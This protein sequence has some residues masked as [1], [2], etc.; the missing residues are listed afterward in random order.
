MIE[1]N[2]GCLRDKGGIVWPASPEYGY[3]AEKY[4]R[5][6]TGQSRK[7]VHEK[8]KGLVCLTVVRGET[9]YKSQCNTLNN[10]TYHQQHVI[11]QL[12]STQIQIHAHEHML[13]TESYKRL[14]LISDTKQLQGDKPKHRC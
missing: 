13:K 14:Y 10:T 1:Q 8:E 2:S 5:R 9:E 4:Q 11:V 3:S 7:I 6:K 12:S